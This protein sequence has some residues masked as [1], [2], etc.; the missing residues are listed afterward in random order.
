MR[1]IRHRTYEAHPT[2]AT[3]GMHPMSDE[4]LK[5]LDELKRG[6]KS[7]EANLAAKIDEVG[8]WVD[9]L[10]EIM[11]RFLGSY[12]KHRTWTTNGLTRV[13][14]AADVDLDSPPK[15]AVG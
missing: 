14:E 7:L 15:V 1:V 11:L 6:Q 2:T 5:A 13:A 8:T 9:G 10:N 4:I 12:K 3:K